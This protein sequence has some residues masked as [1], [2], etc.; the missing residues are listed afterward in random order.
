MLQELCQLVLDGNEIQQIPDGAFYSL[1]KLQTL[2][3]SRLPELTNV[4]ALS[5]L[6][7]L[8]E[9]RISQN[10]RLTSLHV[11]VDEIQLRNVTKVFLIF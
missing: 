9:L 2:S 1:S 5:G 8:H 3:M 10:P 4:G 11:S 7:A 6:V